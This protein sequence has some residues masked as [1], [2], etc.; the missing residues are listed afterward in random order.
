MDMQPQ[1]PLRP[2]EK[3][4]LLGQLYERNPEVGDVIQ[5]VVRFIREERWTLSTGKVVTTYRPP[6]DAILEGGMELSMFVARLAK[7]AASVVRESDRTVLL[8]EA[9]DMPKGQDPAA[10]HVEVVRILVLGM[11]PA[12]PYDLSL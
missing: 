5:W 9:E 6:E 4:P 11:R 12:T 2:G 8:E 3:H 10:G 7:H 1:N